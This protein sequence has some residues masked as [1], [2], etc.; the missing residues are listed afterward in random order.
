[1]A[2]GIQGENVL[3]KDVFYTVSIHLLFYYKSSA[4]IFAL[5]S[6]SVPFFLQKYLHVRVVE[7]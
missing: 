4:Y 1:M 7:Y 5:T 6:C 3:S 2:D